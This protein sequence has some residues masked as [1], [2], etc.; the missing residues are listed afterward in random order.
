[1]IRWTLISLVM[2]L[3]WHVIPFLGRLDLS[4]L[5]S[6]RPRPSHTIAAPSNKMSA[7]ALEE[8]LQS[9]PVSNRAPRDVRCMPGTNGWDYV[10]IYRTGDPFPLSRLKIG[11]RV[12]PTEILQASAP[13]QIES[14]LPVP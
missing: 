9:A 3:A 7:R 11:V 4:G 6:A 2:T 12:S 13:H 1:M 14:Q 8:S 10:C 5:A